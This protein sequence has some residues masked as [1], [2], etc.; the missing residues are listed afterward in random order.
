MARTPN[1][2]KDAARDRSPETLAEMLFFL[3]DPAKR[4]ELESYRLKFEVVHGPTDLGRRYTSTW[5]KAHQDWLID[6]DAKRWFDGLP[7]FA[8]GYL[9]GKME[10]AASRGTL[11]NMPDNL[12]RLYTAKLMKLDHEADRSR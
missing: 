12:L 11:D 10:I 9:R 7:P 8:K 2:S 3:P 4:R 6:H 5:P 1:D